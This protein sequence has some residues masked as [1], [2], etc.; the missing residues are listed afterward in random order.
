[1]TTC[2]DTCLHGWSRHLSTVQTL[3]YTAGHRRALDRDGQP[4][5]RALDR[6]AG[7]KGR[8]LSIPT[9]TPLC[10]VYLV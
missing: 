6:D 4:D 5:R 10:L 2:V 8:H 7:S 9:S 1:L 3:V